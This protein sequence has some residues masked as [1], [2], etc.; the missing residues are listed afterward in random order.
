[1]FSRLHFVLVS[2]LALASISTSAS[3]NSNQI[4]ADALAAEADRV[5]HKGITF[6]PCP[7]NAS[8]DCGTLIV[9]VDYRK[10]YGEQVG[11]AVIRARATN[12]ARRI[13]VVVGNP[14]G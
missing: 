3:A 12:P 11:I 13:G 14:G 4:S 7:E 10:P 8:L 6:S 5:P 1:M 9:P 2:A